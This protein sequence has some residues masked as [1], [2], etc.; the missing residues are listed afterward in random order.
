MTNYKK[1]F[2]KD[3]EWKEFEK[4]IEKFQQNSGAD[5]CDDD[6]FHDQPSK[7][8]PSIRKPKAN[9]NRNADHHQTDSNTVP[10]RP[11]YGSAVRQ[12]MIPQ[13]L[14]GTSQPLHTIVEEVESRGEKIITPAEDSISMTKDMLKNIVSNAF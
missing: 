14:P 1:K 10:L 12:G 3:K 5:S 13:V 6:D 8:R 2:E 11:T 9:G 7:Q 4:R